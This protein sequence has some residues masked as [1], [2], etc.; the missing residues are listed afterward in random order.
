M[1]EEY[2]GGSNIF[3]TAVLAEI[4]VA[5]GSLA[6]VDARHSLTFVLR[7]DGRFEWLESTDAPHDDATVLVERRDG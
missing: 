1:L 4:D 7:S 3:V 2:I 6:C 5:S